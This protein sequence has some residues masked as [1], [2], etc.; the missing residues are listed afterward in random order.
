LN[1]LLSGTIMQLAAAFRFCPRCGAAIAE[2][3][4]NPLRCVACDFT[5]YFSPVTGVVCIIANAAGE[6]LLFRR[7]REPGQGLFGL[8]GG[9]VDPGESAHDA[10]IREV[11]EETSLQVIGLTYLG[12]F[13]NQYEYHGVTIP[14]TDLIYAC[15]VASFDPLCAH[16]EE[17]S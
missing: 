3:G 14:V 7:A 4:R 16:S 15:D 1:V 2:P 6:I 11:R 10:A 17:I 5:Y 8:P 13:P 9:F 12:S